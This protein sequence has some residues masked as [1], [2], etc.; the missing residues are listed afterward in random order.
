MLEISLD[1]EQNGSERLTTIAADKPPLAH[2]SVEHRSIS[3]RVVGAACIVAAGICVVAGLFFAGLT[4]KDAANRDFIEYW[5]AAQQLVHG[6]NPYDAL[7][8]FRLEHAA[9]LDGNQPKITFSP[10]VEF[11]LALPLGFVS[12]KIGLVLWLLALLACLSLSNWMIWLLNGKPDNR[13]HLFGYLFAPA[14]ACQMAGQLGIFLLLSVLLF[15]RFHQ[16]RPYIAGAAL[17]PCALKPHLF[18][19]MALVLV[20]WSIDRKTCRVL[21]GFASALIAGSALTLCFD[22][23]IWLQYS[24]MMSQTGVL[25]AFVPTL[26]VTL[27]FLINRNAVWLQFVPEICACIWAMLYFRA[28]RRCWSWTDQGMLLLLISALCTPYAWFTD[29]AI[30]LPVVIAALYRAIAN[31]RSLWL[32]VLFAGVALIE[33]LGVVKITSPFYLWTVPAWLIW[34]LYATGGRRLEVATDVVAA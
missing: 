2:S 22:R 30:L 10:P 33:V 34:H 23:Q 9:G 20:L 24:E 8:T 25:H 32:F 3:W 18:L 27:R 26:S 1:R 29:E 19:P 28:Q 6:A 11:V 4:E 12:A 31:K 17:L 14:I 7:Q 16:S 5:A 21:A 13:V 15:F